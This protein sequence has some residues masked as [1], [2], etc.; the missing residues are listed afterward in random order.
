MKK[1][2]IFDRSGTLLNNFDQ[3]YE[4]TMD[5]FEKLEGERISKEE[6]RIKNI[7][8]YMKFWNKYFPN[9]KKE[10]QDTLFL[11]SLKTAKEPKLYT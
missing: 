1:N 11:S 10:E 9:L 4:I 3:F 8:P 5:V 2:I 7:S 6:Y